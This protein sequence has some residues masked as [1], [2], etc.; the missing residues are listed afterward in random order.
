MMYTRS[1]PL[2][3]RIR[4]GLAPLGK[5]VGISEQRREQDAYIF[6]GDHGDLFGGDAVGVDQSGSSGSGF[7]WCAQ[8]RAAQGAEVAR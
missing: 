2:H 4:G 3:D 1:S 7:S 5:L 6:A 8:L